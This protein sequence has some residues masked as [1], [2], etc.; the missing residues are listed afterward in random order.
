MLT[1][2]I[3]FIKSSA[4]EGTFNCGCQNYNLL[5]IRLVQCS[6][7]QHNC[8]HRRYL[9]CLLHL[10]RA[11]SDTCLVTLSYDFLDFCCKDYFFC[12]LHSF[13]TSG[14]CHEMWLWVIIHVSLFYHII[15][16]LCICLVQ[17]TEERQSI[18][19]LT[20]DGDILLT[21]IWCSIS[22]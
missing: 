17:I 12:A 21:S 20:I 5:K 7:E 13:A 11:Y 15:S 3:F 8:R 19:L 6:T 14:F 9:L 1:L 2:G 18:K 10:Q 22:V 16:W 4:H